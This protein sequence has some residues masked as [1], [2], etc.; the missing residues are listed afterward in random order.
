MD[1]L[2][3]FLSKT[4]NMTD[5]QLS[6]MLY[7]TDEKGEK[8]IKEDALD[9]LL[10]ADAGRISSIKAKNQEY[11]DNGY[12][13][14]QKETLSKVESE[15]REKTGF[16]S[17]KQGLDLFL[18]YSE[19]LKNQ[20]TKLSDDEFK[21]DKRFL[22]AEKQWKSK[23]EQ[24][25]NTVKTDYEG[26]LSSYEKEKKSAVLS[27]GINKIISGLDVVL[28]K[29]ETAKNNQ[30]KAFSQLLMSSNEFDINGDD[31]IVKKDG[32]RLEDKH[33]NMIAFDDFVKQNAYNYFEKAEAQR[34]TNQNDPESRTQGF[35]MKK[36]ANKEE[37]LKMLKEV[38]GDKEK[39]IAL[40]KLFNEK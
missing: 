1:I 24:E 26:K 8:N 37:Y 19:S 32:A 21:L 38:A 13:K 4:L 16:N 31:V 28:P 6:E 35:Q 5:E 29:S 17:D 14:A 11:F 33:G 3:A 36:P 22:E 23:I 34:E 9:V 30:V 39:E 15:F 7:N 20:K 10:Q 18:D 2:N 12:K 25:V 27:A 40:Y